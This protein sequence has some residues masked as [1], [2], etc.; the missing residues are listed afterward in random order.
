MDATTTQLKRLRADALYG[1]KKHFNAADRKN[2][3][4]NLLNVP[5][6]AI[7][8]ILSS[9]L[10]SNFQKA[11]PDMFKWV[12]ATL[13]IA[14][15]LLTGLATYWKLPKQV[16]GHRRIAHKFLKVMKGCERLLA[17]E[18][19]GLVDGKTFIVEFQ[20]LASLYDDA[21]GEEE[22]FMPNAEDFEKAKKGIASGEEMYLENEIDF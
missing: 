11:D 22:S 7:N 5:S 10:L 4:S 16:E 13:A 3:E 9:V 8:V 19:D 18:K 20:V 6:L 21:N 1:K 12:S 2:R 14:A 15:T 17:F